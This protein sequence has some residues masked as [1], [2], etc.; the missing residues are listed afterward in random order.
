MALTDRSFKRLEKIVGRD[1]CTRRNEDLV[2]YAYDA[3]GRQFLPDA[4]IFPADASEISRILILANEDRFFVTPRG[5]GS[6]MTG[7]AIPVQGGVVMVLSR[8]NHI[9]EID[10]DNLIARAEPGVITG[11]FHKAVEARGLFYPPDPSSAAFS[12]LG[13]NVAECAGGPRAVKYGVTRDYVLGLEVVLPTGQIMKT[14]VMTAK[15]VVGYDLTRLITGAEGTLGVITAITLRLLPLPEA[16][17]TMVAFFGD[18][19]IAAE[20]VSEIIRARIIP[21]TIEYID[22]AAIGCVSSMMTSSLPADAD[23]MLILEV[24]GAPDANAAAMTRLADICRQK[25]AIDVRVASDKEDAESIW[26]A[27]K[28]ISPALYVYGPDKIN[29]D[30][31]VPRSRIP[32]M[33]EKIQAL[34]KETGLFMASFGHAGDGN[35]HVNIMLDKRDPAQVEKAEQAVDI[36]FDETVAL[37]GTI[38]GEHGIGITKSAYMPKEVGQ[39]EIALMKEIKALF[40]PRGILNPGKIFLSS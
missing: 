11:D 14:G 29:E 18:M 6:G 19:R 33:V 17:N 32:E 15:G 26:R 39:A 16:V 27:R 12:T 9:L 37:G 23:A 28:A 25:G 36:L 20:A 3:T 5:T 21:R 34:K 24:D 8:L 2:C 1:N 35:I 22:K 40:D 38:S 7:G 13:G 30:I 31:V 10:T 4:V